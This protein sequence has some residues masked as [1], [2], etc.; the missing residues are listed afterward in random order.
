MA[1]P[2]REFGSQEYK[3]DAEVHNFATKKQGFPGLLMK[4]GNV[5]G[6]DAPDVWKF[7]KTETG[8]PDP[9]WNFNGKFLV[10]KEG[11]VSVPKGNVEQAI[12]GL[13]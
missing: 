13:M 10:S 5:L 1:F 3:T 6:N 8:A 2:S 12:E 9:T 7:F 4:L 11:A